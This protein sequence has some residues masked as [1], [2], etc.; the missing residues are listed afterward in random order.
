MRPL[1]KTTVVIWSTYDGGNAELSALA[2]DA[3]EGPTAIC[4]GYWSGYVADPGTDA[5][6]TD[7][8]E[9]FFSPD[10]D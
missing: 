7:D 2:R 4:T 9:F 3:E 1:Y 10:D 8:A 6:W 5:E